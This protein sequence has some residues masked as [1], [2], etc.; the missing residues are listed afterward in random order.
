MLLSSSLIHLAELLFG[1]DS[2]VLINGLKYTFIRSYLLLALNNFDSF[3]AFLEFQ[4]ISQ[5]Q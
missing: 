3:F 5:S 1:E 4:Q 2:N